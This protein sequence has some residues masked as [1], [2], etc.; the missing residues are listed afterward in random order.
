M[1]RVTASLAHP[2]HSSTRPSTKHSRPQYFCSSFSGCLNFLQTQAT[3]ID[4]SH[5]VSTKKLTT[6]PPTHPGRYSPFPT[7]CVPSFAASP[8]GPAPTA[9]GATVSGRGR[10]FSCKM[11]LFMVRV[12]LHVSLPPLCRLSPCRPFFLL[13][14]VVPDLA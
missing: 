12:A 2:M 8:F 3:R 1:P 4:T 13:L 6:L 9:M 10:A 14:P 5:P 7:T 11:V